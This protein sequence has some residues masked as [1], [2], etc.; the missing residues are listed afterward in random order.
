M[1]KY[2][3]TSNPVLWGTIAVL[4]GLIFVIWPDSVVRWAVYLIGIISLVA[5]VVQFLGFLAQTKAME[6]RWRYFPLTSALAVLWGI[7]LLARPGFWV[8]FFMILFGVAMLFIAVGQLISLARI[9]KSGTPVTV[10]Y[11]VF[12]ALMLLAAIV[13]FFNPFATTVWLVVFVGAWIIAYGI[14]EMFSYFSLRSPAGGDK[15]QK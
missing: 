8:E 4:I 1:E 5:G 9:R 12:P 15:L 2:V 3:K 10:G 6:N 14:T 11:F 13:V 7:L